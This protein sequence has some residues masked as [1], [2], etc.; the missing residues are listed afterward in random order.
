MGSDFAAP[1]KDFLQLRP[2]N[3]LELLPVSGVPNSKA[4]ISGLG[5]V[6]F[7]VGALKSENVGGQYSIERLPIQSYALDQLKPM[8][9]A[10]LN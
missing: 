10:I 5:T 4:W 6:V 9:K 3:R 7:T 1:G 2:S 8:P